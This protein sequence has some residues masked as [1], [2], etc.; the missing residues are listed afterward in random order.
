MLVG[1]LGDRLDIANVARG[2]ADALAEDG[3]GIVVDQRFEI[4]GLV[5]D[6]ATRRVSIEGEEVDLTPK[7]F[8]VL[9][10]L[11]SRAPALVTVR[12][13]ALQV[14]TDES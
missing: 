12:E 11:I 3:P 1:N 14:W 13:I 10:L 5:V 7:K 2:I 4:G 8:A 9:E 6:S